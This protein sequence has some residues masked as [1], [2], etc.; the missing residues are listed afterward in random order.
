MSPPFKVL[1]ADDSEEDRFLLERCIRRNSWLQLIG[2]VSDGRQVLQWL[3]GD[4]RYSDRLMFPFPDLLL[5]DAIMVE[6]NALQILN[7]LYNHPFPELK[8]VIFT[9]SSTPAACEEYLRQGAHAC[10]QK[11]V[12]F[13][14]LKKDVGQVADALRAGSY[15]FASPQLV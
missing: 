8:V 12:D 4:G 5:L 1:V 11:A 14:E 15:N 3:A 7:W 10:Y 13:G 2:A 6:A 9:G